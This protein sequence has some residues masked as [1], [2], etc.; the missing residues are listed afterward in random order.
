LGVEFL[1]GFQWHRHFAVDNVADF[2]WIFFEAKKWANHR[3]FWSIKVQVAGVQHP[4]RCKPH[5]TL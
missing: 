5:F 2:T 4:K 3:I 1:F